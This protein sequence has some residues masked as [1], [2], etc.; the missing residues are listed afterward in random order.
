MSPKQL[1]QEWVRRF[2]TGDIDGLSSRDA[3]DAVK[4]QVVMRT[5]KG[6]SVI[7]HLFEV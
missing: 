6:R 7:R 2:N 3:E 5:L 4:H 1:V